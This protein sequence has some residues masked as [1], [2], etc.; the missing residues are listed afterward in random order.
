MRWR[1]RFCVSLAMWEYISDL[2][3]FSKLSVRDM[4]KLRSLIWSLIE[5]GYGRPL[6]LLT[7]SKLSLFWKPAACD[8]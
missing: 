1:R 2:W 8:D 4:T 7:I 3:L 5:R 6:L